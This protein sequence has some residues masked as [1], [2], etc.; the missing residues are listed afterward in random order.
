MRGLLQ[1]IHVVCIASST[2]KPPPLLKRKEK[3]KEKRTR[4]RKSRH[5]LLCCNQ[6]IDAERRE[7]CESCTPTMQM[8]SCHLR[9]SRVFKITKGN[10]NHAQM[11]FLFLRKMCVGWYTGTVRDV[12]GTT[13]HTLSSYKRIGGTKD[14]VRYMTRI[15]AFAK[16]LGVPSDKTQCRT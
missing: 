6:D 12:T 7:W 15:S 2:R 1:D 16:M 3:K 4:G 5:I 9:S 10:R 14:N 8:F 11:H 13:L